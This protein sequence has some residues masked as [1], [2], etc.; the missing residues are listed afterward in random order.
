M[1][2]SHLKT[3]SLKLSESPLIE[4]ATSSSSVHV[5][6]SAEGPLFSRI[7]TASAGGQSSGPSQKKKTAAQLKSLT[8]VQV[9][10]APLSPVQQYWAL[11]AHCC[12]PQLMPARGCTWTP[13]SG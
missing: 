6:R 10:L 9:P 1:G 12:L 3:S 2:R 11:A 7:K 8:A 4:R 13:W 5:M